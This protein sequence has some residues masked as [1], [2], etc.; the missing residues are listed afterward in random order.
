MLGLFLSQWT[1]NHSLKW[2][3]CP[4]F[5]EILR[6]GCLSKPTYLPDYKLHCDCWGYLSCSSPANVGWIPQGPLPAQRHYSLSYELILKSSLGS[7]FEINLSSSIGPWWLLACHLAYRW[8]LISWPFLP[9]HANTLPGH[10]FC[11][12]LSSPKS[13]FTHICSPCWRLSG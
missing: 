2:V 6:S 13:F 12:L 3:S 1:L 11:V 8:L 4:W 5:L 7:L 10:D 9:P